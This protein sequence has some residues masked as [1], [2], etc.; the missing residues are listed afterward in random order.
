LNRDQ[1]RD[2]IEKFG[3]HPAALGPQPVKVGHD[4]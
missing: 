1:V 3:L 4:S 2:R